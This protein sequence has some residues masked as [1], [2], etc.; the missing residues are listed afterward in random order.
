MTMV[1]LLTN[2][3]DD[4]VQIVQDNKMILFSK[5]M[6]IIQINPVE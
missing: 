3:I 2:Q 6:Q 5:I 4:A 1:R